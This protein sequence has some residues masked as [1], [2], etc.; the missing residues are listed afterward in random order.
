MALVGSQ[1]IC[2]V[3]GAGPQTTQST[4]AICTGLPPGILKSRNPDAIYAVHG[5]CFRA[6]ISCNGNELAQGPLSTP[7]CPAGQ[8]CSEWQVDP[9]Q[10]PN[11]RLRRVMCVRTASAAGF[12]APVAK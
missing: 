5:Q 10:G 11:D 1:V 3:E 4:D 12:V 9:Q 8:V 2:R 6:T 7:A